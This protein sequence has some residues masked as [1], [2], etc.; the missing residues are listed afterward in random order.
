[1]HS[2]TAHSERCQV[3]QQTQRTR[4]EIV[5]RYSTHLDAALADFN[6][7]QVFIDDELTLFCVCVLFWNKGKQEYRPVEHICCTTCR[8]VFTKKPPG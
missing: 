5:C 3:S 6:H 2:N 8:H 1:M 7:I 4:P